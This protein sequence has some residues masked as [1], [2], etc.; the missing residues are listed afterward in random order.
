MTEYAVCR[1]CGTSCTPEGSGSGLCPS[2][3]EVFEPPKNDTV[4]VDKTHYETLLKK[5]WCLDRLTEILAGCGFIAAKINE[6]APKAAVSRKFDA[7]RY[8]STIYEG[9]FA[10]KLENHND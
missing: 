3:V 2:C 8:L 6:L 4:R 9:L 1:G 10:P 7:S 5:E